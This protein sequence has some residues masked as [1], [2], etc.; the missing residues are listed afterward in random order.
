MNYLN[1]IFVNIW[2]IETA[3]HFVYRNKQPQVFRSFKPIVL[4]I[5]AQ[6]S[7]ILSAVHAGVGKWG[8]YE[9]DTSS[10]LINFFG[11]SIVFILIYGTPSID[12]EELQDFLNPFTP[13]SF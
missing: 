4:T 9:L 3:L 11:S 5:P 12:F 10:S 1:S 7:M 13:I 8:N 6:F 2:L